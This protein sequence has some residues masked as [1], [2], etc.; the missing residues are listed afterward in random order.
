M[1]I[2]AQ[3]L[4]STL[5][6]AVLFATLQHPSRSA[7]SDRFTHPTC[8][9]QRNYFRC[10][11]DWRHDSRGLALGLLPPDELFVTIPRSTACPIYRLP[12]SISTVYR[13]SGLS[14]TTRQHFR[15]RFT[16]QDKVTSSTDSFFWCQPLR[17]RALR[18]QRLTVQRFLPLRSLLN[19]DMRLSQR[20]RTAA[21]LCFSNGSQLRLQD[22]SAT[23]TPIT[24]PM[25]SRRLHSFMA[26]RFND[27]QQDTRLTPATRFPAQRSYTTSSTA[28]V[29]FYL[30]YNVSSSHSL[31]QVFPRRRSFDLNKSNQRVYSLSFST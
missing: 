25:D 13:F 18:Q 16:L 24:A 23:V 31:A 6:L 9:V 10:H 15:T 28:T 2:G 7:C 30:P 3:T 1:L 4:R 29:R 20:T 27:L 11:T 5:P 19:T 17:N 21:L 8:V 26:L 14:T 12:L 22:K